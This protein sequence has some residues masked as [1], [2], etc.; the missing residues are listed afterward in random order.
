MRIPRLH[1][2][3]G[4][5]RVRHR[6]L[7]SYYSIRTEALPQLIEEEPMTMMMMMMTMM[8][9]MMMMLRMMVMMMTM[10]MPYDSAEWL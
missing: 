2:D 9:M 5:E 7:P 6:L 10:T 3:V 4:A 1:G 8:I